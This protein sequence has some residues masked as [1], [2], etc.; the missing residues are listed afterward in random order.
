VIGLSILANITGRS[1]SEYYANQRAATEVILEKKGS[2]PNPIEMVIGNLE[3]YERRRDYGNKVED[4]SYLAA[5]IG[6]V[7]TLVGRIKINRE[8]I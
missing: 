2:Q 3:K 7:A 5:V 4:R 6:G 8:G 1:L